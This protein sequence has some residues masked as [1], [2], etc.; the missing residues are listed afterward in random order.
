MNLLVTGGAGFIGSN[1]I[2][3]LMQETDFRVVNFD[4]LTY[5]GRR[6]NCVE[7][8][9]SGRYSF[10]QGDIADADAVRSA[11]AQ[12]G[13]DAVVNFAAESHVD[14]SIHDAG[15]FIRTNVLGTQV[16]LDSAREA[17]IGRFVHVSTDEVYGDLE[18]HEPA[19]TE[20]SPFRPSSPYAASKAAAD[21]LVAAAFRTHGYP[22][23]ITRCSNNYGPYQFP[24]KF[25][26]LAISRAKKNEPIPVYG[27]GENVRDWIHVVDHCR[28]V[29]A[30]LERGKAG[31]A[32]N[33]GGS[34]EKRNLDI[35]QAIL[36]LMGRSE[37]LLRFVA[38]RPG[39]DLRY[40]M[41][42][43]KATA[44]LGW[45][46]LISFDEGLRE[47]I[48]WYEKND[49]WLK[50]AATPEHDAFLAKHYGEVK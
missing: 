19:F 22:G 9:S 18:A 42:F 27:N 21:M 7:Y 43:T 16:L 3:L 13:I 47:T 39:H 48:S 14:R 2:R 12:K 45:K 32:Y 31:E 1:F 6:G 24:E 20:L 23:I 46:P 11:I 41:N 36:K 5:A 4:L 8:E 26:P 44:E 40:A 33:F 15:S 50:D 17:G 38:D 25:M 37:T 49:A 10:V 30:A 29:M 35:V 34:C 28:G